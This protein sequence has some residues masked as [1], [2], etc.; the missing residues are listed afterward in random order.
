M[1]EETKNL[2]SR[3]R[4][5]RVILGIAIFVFGIEIS[6]ISGL[7]ESGYFVQGSLQ[8]VVASNIDRFRNIY[9][10][11]AWFFGFVLFFTGSTGF[12]PIYKIIRHKGTKK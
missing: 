2:S 12:C 6:S 3:E 5:V 9:R 11:L 8:F 4:I 10:V 1:I 7:V